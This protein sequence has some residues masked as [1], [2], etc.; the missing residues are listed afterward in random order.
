MSRALPPMN[1]FRVFEVAARH[2]K[3]TAAADELGM[4]QSAVSQQIRSLEVRLGTQLF[5]RQ[6]RGLQL[7]DSARKLLPKVSL[8]MEHLQ[9]ATEMFDVGTPQNVLTIATSVSVAQWLIAPNLQSFTARYPEIYVRLLS[10]I[11]ADDFRSSIAD[12]EIRFGSVAQVGKN[13][14]RLGPDGLVAVTVNADPLECD[15]IEAV[16]TS[17]GWRQWCIAAD[18]S[19]PVKPNVFVDSY[20]MAITLAYQGAG[21]ALVS[22]LLAR[23]LLKRRELNSV[24]DIEIPSSEGYFLATNP[25]NPLAAKFSEWL[26]SIIEKATL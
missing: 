11:W 1:W 16:G 25:E 18:V 3:F 21:T 7:T 5:I 6:S 12:V 17:E 24:K 14:T 8:S 22:S 13:A 2:L 9:A 23:P 19:N 10:T 20:G 26:M 4:T 15:L